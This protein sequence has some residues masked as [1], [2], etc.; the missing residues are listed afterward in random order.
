MLIFLTGNRPSMSMRQCAI[1]VLD[2]YSLRVCYW[3]GG[4][5]GGDPEKK[6]LEMCTGQKEPNSTRLLQTHREVTQPK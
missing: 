6:T 4:G 5:G 3:R 1:Q 2:S